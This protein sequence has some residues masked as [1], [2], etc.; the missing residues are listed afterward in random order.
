[1]KRRTL[2]REYIQL[3]AGAGIVIGALTGCGGG[4]SASTVTPEASTT[5]NTS[6]TT[7]PSVLALTPTD[8]E[9]DVEPNKVL[10]A[11][12]SE[13]MFAVTVDDAGFALNGGGSDVSGTVAF[14]PL[15]NVATFTPATPLALLTTYTATLNN[16]ITDLSGNAL[17][18]ES[19]SF[20]TRDGT[21]GDGV[22]IESDG[23]SAYAPRISVDD[24][25]NAIAVWS[26][27]IDGGQY[28]LAN[29]YTA[30]GGWGSP[31]L[32]ESE[33]GGVSSP[34]VG[35]DA[36]GN[37]MAMWAKFDGTR[38]NVWVNH[39]NSESRAWGTAYLLENDDTFS[40]SDPQVVFEANGD[41]VA[42][43]VSFQNLWV[44][45]YDAAASMWGT[46]EVI[47]SDTN[48]AIDSVDMGMDA[49][50]NIVAVWSQYH[51]RSGDP[52]R[53]NMW[54][55]RYNATD[56]SWGT[57]ALLE[58]DDVTDVRNPSIGVDSRGNALVVWNT[59]EGSRNS[60]WS[61]FYN[62]GDESWT[63][64]TLVETDDGSAYSPS[65]AFDDNGNGMAVW[66]QYS[67]ADFSGNKDIRVNHFNMNTGWATPVT[68]D[69]K[70]NIAFRPDIVLDSAGNALVVWGQTN[71]ISQSDIW[72]SRYRVDTGWGDAEVLGSDSAFYGYLPHL[73]GNGQGTAMVVW[74]M[75]DSDTEA[76]DIWS[77]RF[78]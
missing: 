21:W 13:D 20:T 78:E 72:G 64:P 47:S 29:H 59:T 37:G 60:I 11:T 63:I 75:E 51:S 27:Y 58:H 49:D 1:M 18:Q 5:Q 14:D 68:L 61:A 46:P 48:G 42:M 73:A 44:K 53:Y 54:A 22:A 76:G 30:G 65:I 74:R 9:G 12:F 19:V 7:A 2:N 69:I 50:G 57:A 39:Y 71:D 15:T 38:F 23:G 8:G 34:F 52:Y 16:T 6:D 62:A 77:N 66:E 24:K 32:I 17:S 4:G 26:Q 36:Q 40:A 33:A 3:L 35:T 55:N 31:E 43:W 25:G 67:G 56:D 70:D 10:S 41:A 45:R 28:M